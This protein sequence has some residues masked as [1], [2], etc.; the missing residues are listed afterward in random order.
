MTTEHTKI[1]NKFNEKQD[2]INENEQHLHD[3]IQ[4]LRRD[5]GL[6]LYRKQD[7]EKKAQSNAKK[8][9]LNIKNFEK[10]NGFDLAVDFY[11]FMN[12]D[13]LALKKVSRDR[14]K[15]YSL[16]YHNLEKKNSTDAADD[17]VNYYYTRLFRVMYN[18][19]ND[20]PSDRFIVD[21]NKKEITDLSKN[22]NRMK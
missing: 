8:S 22:T 18:F 13:E 14:I 3:E 9:G 16:I 4:R 19:T 6:E 15:E 21:F 20:T 7:A 1:K 17:T 12:A 2:Q 5:L 11:R 10:G